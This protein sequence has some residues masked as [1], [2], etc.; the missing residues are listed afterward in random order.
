MLLLKVRKNDLKMP[1]LGVFGKRSFVKGEGGNFLNKTCSP[2]EGGGGHT[3]GTVEDRR[4]GF[5]LGF[6]LRDNISEVLLL[7]K[8]IE[9]F[10]NCWWIIM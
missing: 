7:L 5:V 6:P 1:F 10:L 2:G 9:N 3:L 4:Y 8:K